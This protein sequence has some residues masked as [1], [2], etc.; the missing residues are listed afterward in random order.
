MQNPKIPSKKFARQPKRKTAAQ[1]RIMHQDMH[2][3]YGINPGDF[4]IY[5][6][7]CKVVISTPGERVGTM[8]ARVFFLQMGWEGSGDVKLRKRNS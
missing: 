7:K 1:S 8:A 6:H 2:V 4:H 3:T 5:A